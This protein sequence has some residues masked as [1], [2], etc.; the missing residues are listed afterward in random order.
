MIMNLKFYMDKYNPASN[1]FQAIY[2]WTLLV[3]SFKGVMMFSFPQ[4]PQNI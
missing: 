1:F 4:A 2:V 3:L